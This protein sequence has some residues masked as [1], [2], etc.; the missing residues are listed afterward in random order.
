LQLVGVG[1][2]HKGNPGG[3]PWKGRVF[4]GGTSPL[5]IQKTRV[6]RG[7]RPAKFSLH[8]QGETGRKLKL[9]GPMRTVQN[10]KKIT[11]KKTGIRQGGTLG[12][13]PLNHTGR[14]DEV[15]SLSQKLTVS[16]GFKGI[17]TVEDKEGYY[18]KKAVAV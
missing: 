4:Q 10:Y 11:W 3:E 14:G 12:G 9:V 18:H 7:G 13:F 15:K 17:R 16:V 8:A 2:G 6:K 1:K 5:R